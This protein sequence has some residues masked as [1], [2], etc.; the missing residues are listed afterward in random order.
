MK[1]GLILVFLLLAPL[2]ALAQR[3][4][5]TVPF[6]SVDSFILVDAKIDGTPVRLLVDTGAN[7]SIPRCHNLISSCRIA[8]RN[9]FC[10]ETRST[11]SEGVLWDCAI[12]GLKNAKQQWPQRTATVMARVRPPSATS[13]RC[14]L[15]GRA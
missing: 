10:C 11:V 14:I 3:R 12:A 9:V 15:R 5:V 7:T 6:R 4:I 13:R 1:R 8:I 2:Q